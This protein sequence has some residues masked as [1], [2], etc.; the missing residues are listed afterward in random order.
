[1][2]IK[3]GP[4]RLVTGLGLAVRVGDPAR[5]LKGRTQIIEGGEPPKNRDGVGRVI[6]KGGDYAPPQRLDLFWVQEEK[7]T[8]RPSG[9]KE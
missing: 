2:E 8:Q 6:L 3:N 1:M 5:D 9:G 4:W 7:E